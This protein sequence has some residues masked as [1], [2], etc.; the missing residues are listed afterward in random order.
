[1]M[2]QEKIGGVGNIY[3]NESLWKAKI[4]PTTP[5]SSLSREQTK[6]LFTSLLAVLKDGMK[7]GG[8][9][10]LAYVRA[11]GTDGQYQRHFLA[12]AQQGKLCQRCEKE[13]KIKI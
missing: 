7:Y 11:D 10:E 6:L 1:M 5:A 9:S 12:Y 3:A 8:S 13:K 4:N 2:D